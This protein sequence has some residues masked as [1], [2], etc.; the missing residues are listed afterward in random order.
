MRRK[1][2]PKSPIATCRGWRLP[3]GNYGNAT[4]LAG[5]AGIDHPRNPDVHI[6][7]MLGLFA[8]GDYRGSAMEAHAVAAMGR[9][10]DWAAVYGLYGNVQPYTDQLRKLEKFVDQ[11]PTAAEGR[12]LLGFQYMIA[13]HKDAARDQFAQAVKLTPR[14]TLAAKLLTQVGG[15]APAT[16]APQQPE[17]ATRLGHASMSVPCAAVMT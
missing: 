10:P 15:T 4:R 12:F 7:A 14:D 2:A 17:Q 9:I 5:H 1:P 8:M 11:H 13:G 16:P 6:L 3:E